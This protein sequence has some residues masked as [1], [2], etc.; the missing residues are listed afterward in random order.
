ERHAE[1]EGLVLVGI[2]RRGAD[3]AKRLGRL[4][5]QKMST[6]PTIGTLDI[7]LY[8]DDWDKLSTQPPINTSHIPHKLDEQTVVLIDDVLFSGRTVRAALD[9]LLA[10]GRP[11]KVE[12]LVLI[13]RGH[14]ELPI[15][16]DY[17]GKE[18]VTRSDEKVQVWLTERDGQDA[19]NLITK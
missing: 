19:V 9:A 4:L 17:V 16:A 10:Y 14:R 18:V 11:K 2:E 13:D 12:L 5:A 15:Q 6:P 3:L 1:D 7:N 8:R